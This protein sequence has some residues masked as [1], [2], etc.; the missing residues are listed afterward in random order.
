MDCWTGSVLKGMLYKKDGKADKGLFWWFG[1]S[2]PFFLVVRTALDPLS[3]FKLSKT[4]DINV[5]AVY[6]VAIGLLSLLFV[7]DRWRAGDFCLDRVA[8]AFMVFLVFL[9]FWVPVAYFNFGKAGLLCATR[10]W[11][12][13]FVIFTVYLAFYQL[14]RCVGVDRVITVLFLSL[15]VP[16]A[17][18][19]R[20]IFLGER[21]IWGSL[22][23]PNPFAFYLAFFM[24]L[25]LWK[26]RCGNKKTLWIIFLFVEATFLCLTWSK[27]GLLMATLMLVFF[28]LFT[29]SWRFRVLCLSLV[30]FMGAFWVVSPVGRYRL[31]HSVPHLKTVEKK[32]TVEKEKKITVEKEKKT[33]ENE[34]PVEN[35]SDWRLVHWKILLERWKDKPLMGYGLDTSEKFVSPWHALPHNDYVKFLVETG[36][37]GFLVWI[38]FLLVVGWR[39]LRGPRESCNKHL[40]FTLLVVFLAWQMSALFSNQWKATCF[41]FYFWAVAGL[42]LGTPNHEGCSTQ[43]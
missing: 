27:G 6:G 39:F 12:R 13:A 3:E 26:A 21:R 24:G 15:P 18:A 23:H 17:M 19:T 2:L 28:L 37:V 38:T 9:L 5:A 36:I 31:K 41:L 35:S 14:A 10:E 33:S 11:I 22:P 16:L 32:I 29:G 42:V 34:I 8:K 1:L 4:M 43:E 30:V 7:A 40:A 25:T 20:Q